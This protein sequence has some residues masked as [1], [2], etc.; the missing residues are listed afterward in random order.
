MPP[1]HGGVVQD[2]GQPGV[3][4]GPPQVDRRGLRGLAEQ[5]DPRF[6]HLG[7]ARRGRVAG[8]HAGDRDDGLLTA[9]PHDLQRLRVTHHHLGQARTVPHD[10]ERHRAE[11]PAAVD[12]AL[13][14]DR[15]AGSGRRQPGGQG[16]GQARQRG[17]HDHHLQIGT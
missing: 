15:P 12:P 1:G 13:Q 5:R 4:R 10:E 3:E 11:H 2:G 14:A 6:G 16:A 17:C 8:G 9:A 7:A